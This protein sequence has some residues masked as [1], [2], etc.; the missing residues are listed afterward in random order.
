MDTLLPPEL[1][2]VLGRHEDREMLSKFLE[3]MADRQSRTILLCVSA[4]AKTIEEISRE[5]GVPL[6]TCYRKAKALASKGLIEAEGIAVRKG[7]RHDKYRSAFTR[8][9]LTLAK[10]GVS[11]EASRD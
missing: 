10:E 6:S 3:A 5:G 8:L 2:S 7:R 9:T 1:Q 11:V 4:R